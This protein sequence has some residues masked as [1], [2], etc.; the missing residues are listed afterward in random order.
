MGMILVVDDNGD[1]RFLLQQMLSLNGYS[2]ISAVNGQDALDK[3]HN[4][5]PDLV[6]MDMAMPVKDGWTATAEL[7]AES[8]YSHI[9]V[10]AVTGHTTYNELSRATAAGCIDHLEK[11]IDYEVLVNKVAQYLKKNEKQL[12]LGA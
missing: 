8:R 6:L 3:V 12:A 10:I 9:P 5:T 11:P 4:T 2:V 1:N 7:K